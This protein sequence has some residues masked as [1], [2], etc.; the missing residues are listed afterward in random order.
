M[1]QKNKVE[2]F[3]QLWFR[4]S[5]KYLAV[6]NNSHLR[7][8]ACAI[9]VSLV[10]H[11]FIYLIFISSVTVTVRFK[12]R[13]RVSWRVKVRINNYHVAQI[14]YCE[15]FGNATYL[16]WPRH[17]AI[18]WTKLRTPCMLQLYYGNYWQHIHF[19]N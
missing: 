17:C 1:H 16:A 13:V 12:V 3:G 19:T 5:I 18:W 4:C 2:D 7:H 8:C 11:C 10:R 9:S 6:P 14:S 15:L